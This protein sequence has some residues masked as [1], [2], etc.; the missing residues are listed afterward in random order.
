MKALDPKN[1]NESENIRRKAITITVLALLTVLIIIAG[2]V[3]T[4]KMMI[5]FIFTS[6]FDI[7]IVNQTSS[8]ISGLKITYLSAAK[9]IIVPDI[10]ANSQVKLNVNPSENFGE[11]SMKIYYFDKAGNRHEETIVGYFEKGYSGKSNAEIKSIDD[12]GILIV[13][14]KEEF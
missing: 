7:S 14:V 13:K 5:G 8:K 1:I 9:D 12:A 11:N 2:I 10:N 6:G 4:G 3:A